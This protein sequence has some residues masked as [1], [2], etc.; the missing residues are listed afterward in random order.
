MGMGLLALSAFFA[1]PVVAAECSA[2][3]SAQSVALLELYTSEGCSSCPPADRWLS[4]LASQGYTSDRVIPLA[5]HVDY[6]DYIGWQDKFA[7]PG[8]AA[9]Q[10]EMAGLS[11]SGFVYTPQVLLNGRDYRNWSSNSRLEADIAAINRIPAHANI[12]LTLNQPTADSIE[13]NASAQAARQA[14]PVLYVALYE[15]DLNSSVKAGENSGA[16]LHHDY[17]VREWLGPYPIDEKT[18]APWQ[19]KITLKPDWKKKDLGAVAFVQ[20][21][22]SGEILQ[23]VELKLCGSTQ[24]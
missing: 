17:V 14:S 16:Q 23:A 1:S 20:N 9:R 5:L 12:K 3:S 7:K 11:R 15:N 2:S 8:F 18:I 4:K 22:A 6:W 13:V 24:H 10:R 21:R 19:Q